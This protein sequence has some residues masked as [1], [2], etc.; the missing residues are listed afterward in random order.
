MSLAFEEYAI[1]ENDKFNEN[2]LTVFDSRTGSF[3]D[4]ELL[5]D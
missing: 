5:I 1:V 4:F 2:S 3:A